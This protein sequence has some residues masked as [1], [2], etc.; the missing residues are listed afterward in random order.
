MVGKL[1]EI[2]AT[3]TDETGWPATDDVALVTSISTVS[4]WP[5][6]LVRYSVREGGSSAVSVGGGWEKFVADQHL[7]PGAFMTFEVVDERRLV[8]TVHARSAASD[9]EFLRQEPAVEATP[10]PCCRDIGPLPVDNNKPPASNRR[11]ISKVPG[12]SLPQFQ[13]T[14]RKTHMKDHD[15]GRLVRP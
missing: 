9:S 6:K 1:Q 12:Q 15:G 3:F 8:V 2:P 7:Q 4:E 13:K 5:L 14:L 11:V 10:E